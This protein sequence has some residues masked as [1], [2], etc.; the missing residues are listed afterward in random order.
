MFGSRFAV[1]GSV[2]GSIFSVRDS[3][4]LSPASMKTEITDVTE[5]QKTLTIEIPSDVVD[6]EIARVARDLSRQVRLP[7]FRPGK[8]PATV[9]KQRFR[10]Q[11]LHD[12]MHE[13]TGRAVAQA[14]EERGIDP[15]DRPKVAHVDIKEG[16]PLTFTAAVETVPPF[17]PGDV[18]SITVTRPPSIVTDDAVDQT[19]ERLRQRAGKSEPVEGR[20][21][22]D[23]DVA[24]LDITRVEAGQEPDRHENVSLELGSAA[25]PPGF[26][27]NLIGLSVGDEKTFTVRFPEDYQVKEMAGTEVTY[28]VTV[29]DLRH[30]VLPELDDEFAKDLGEFDSLAAL[31]ERVREDMHREAE[32]A[33]R[34]Q[35][36]TDVLKQL[37][38]RVSFELPASLVDRELDRRLEEFVRQLMQQDIDPRQAGIDWAQFR[39]SQRETARASVASALVLDEIARREQ[40]NV[41]DEDVEREIEQFAAQ[42]QRTPAAIRAQL[43]KDDDLGRIRS[44]L[45]REKTVEHVLGLVTI[46][47]AA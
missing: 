43:E 5:T 2:P 27:A 12:V 29:K 39:E 17:D 44:G 37:A 24:V 42:A 6:A 16:Q 21:I 30:L 7:G 20:P 8:V 26:D 13:L 10:D 38:E 14:L 41:S 47:G 46:Q 34:R 9:V 33:S 18:S 45:R 1:R 35:L 19:L 40:I 23:G 32:E 15:I 28:T 3:T 11:I 25:N 31:R 22:A 4:F 36:R